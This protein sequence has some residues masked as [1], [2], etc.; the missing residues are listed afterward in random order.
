MTFLGFFVMKNKLHPRSESEI[1]SL[2]NSNILSKMI[3]GDSIYTAISVAKECCIV[4]PLTKVL[5]AEIKWNNNEVGVV[6]RDVDDGTY[7]A[8]MVSDA[9]TELAITGEAFSLLRNYFKN[10]IQ[11]VMYY[12]VGLTLQ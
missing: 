6:W 8:T 1:I 12:K 10:D 11:R 4:D 3:T 2:R 9:S 7:S 5:V